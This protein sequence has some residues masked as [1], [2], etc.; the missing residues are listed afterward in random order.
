[1]RLFVSKS[2]PLVADFILWLFKLAWNGFAS[3]V[4]GQ[5]CNI[6]ISFGHWSNTHLSTFRAW[7]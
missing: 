7:T 1:L 2:S 3:D 6:Q 4:S 5:Y